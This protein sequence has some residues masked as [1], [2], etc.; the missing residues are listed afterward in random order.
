M[1]T[2]TDK[3][4][5][6]ISQEF[7]KKFPNWPEPRKGA[8]EGIGPLAGV[9]MYM[10][11]NEDRKKWEEEKNKFKLFLDNLVDN[12][13]VEKERYKFDETIEEAEYYSEVARKNYSAGYN[14]AKKE[15]KPVPHDTRDGYC[16]ACDY[17]ILCMEEE[18]D[19][20]VKRALKVKLSPQPRKE[21]K[22]K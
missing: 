14:D 3:I 16:C 15:R 18:I 5:K 20:R 22:D 1:S 12:I 19:K 21:R 2:N 4:K 8:G 9:G 6:E 7:E 10:Q 13:V 11:Y 17:D